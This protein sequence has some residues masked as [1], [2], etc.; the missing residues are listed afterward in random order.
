MKNEELI[1]SYKEKGYTTTQVAKILGISRRSLY[2]LLEGKMPYES[3][4][5]YTKLIMRLK[6]LYN[7]AFIEEKPIKEEF[8][9]KNKSYQGTRLYDFLYLLS[10]YD[11][12]NDEDII[13][14]C[15][16][17]DSDDEI[18]LSVEQ[19]KE[20]YGNYQLLDYD[21]WHEVVDDSTYSLQGM[22]Q[23][24]NQEPQLEQEDKIIPT[25]TT[26]NITI[27][28]GVKLRMIV[29]YLNG[30]FGNNF[31]P[32]QYADWLVDLIKRKQI[33]KEETK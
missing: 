8:I 33:L 6:P 27:A 12:T 21:L 23:I 25:F 10:K 5:K 20:N 15:F 11:W 22:I 32:K 14:D 26:R 18:K 29:G 13:L 17:D 28:E 3:K 19:L 31:N 7:N 9:K 2:N 4:S 24:F 1:K 30:A 16:I